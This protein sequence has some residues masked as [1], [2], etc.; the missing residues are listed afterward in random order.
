MS[1]KFL[2]PIDLN[3]NEL[4]NAV[5]QQLS[6]ATISGLSGPKGKL[7]Y[8][9]TNNVLKYNT[10]GT[11]GG[12]VALTTGSATTFGSASGL[13]VG[14]STSDGVAGTA[15]RSDHVHALP[16]Y[17][18]VGDIVAETTLGNTGKS[19]GSAN[20]FARADHSH[21]T[22]SMPNARSAK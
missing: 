20:L 19:A 22:P 4:L 14:G 8:D 5:I 11:T 7:V 21:G 6:A 17:G 16:A 10:D 3:N 12:W 9:T 18:A 2:V 13:T 1:R 15:A